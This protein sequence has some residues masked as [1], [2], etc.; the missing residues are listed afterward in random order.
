[1]IIYESDKATFM[2]YV[3]QGIIGDKVYEYYSKKVGN[4]KP[5]E[6]LAWRNSLRNMYS[7]LNTN[8]IPNDAGIAIEYMLPYQYS[9]IDFIVSGKDIRDAEHVIIVE[10][11]Q[12]TE[13]K[14]VVEK[15]LVETFVGGA[16][17]EL[18]H[19]S[20][21]AWSYAETLKEYN[22]TVQED[23]IQLH[24][25]S[26][27]HNYV[28]I[29]NDQLL[30]TIAYPEISSAPIF[31]KDDALELQQF[32]LKYIQKSDENNII[33]R[34]D[35]GKLKPSKSLQDS[36]AKMLEGNREFIMLDSQK[37]IYENIMHAVN[38][39]KN[40]NPSKTV[41]IIKGGPGTGKSVL[42][43][44]LLADIINCD[45]SVAY[46]TKN[47]APRNVYYEKLSGRFRKN[48]VNALFK[49]SGIFYDS[50][51]NAF[52][53]LLID[54]AHRLNEK[55]GLFS[56][57][58]ENQIKEIINASKISVFFIDEDQRVTSKD[59]GSIDLIKHFAKLFNAKIK[60][61]ELESQFR[62]NGSDDYI[63]WLNNL[64]EIKT[65]GYDIFNN[66]D[67]DFKIFD[68]LNEMCEAI[69]EKNKINNKSRIV[70]GYCWEWLSKKD[71]NSYDIVIP[72]E[73]FKAQ[74]NFN[75]TSTWA[76]DEDSINQ[77]GCIH[78][79]QGLEFDYV[80]V[81][82]GNDLRY[83]ND[84]VITDFSKRAKTDKSLSGLITKCRNGDFESLKKADILIRN[85]YK[86]L[87]TRGMKGC[88]VYCT[89]KELS[90][91]IKMRIH[92][93]QTTYAEITENYLLAAETAEHE[94][95]K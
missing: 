77:I 40:E 19:P 60:T 34:I 4:I 95:L 59:I 78:T 81:I 21:Q 88:Y 74:W 6:I 26:F 51:N 25:C 66:R 16:F 68:N 39:M 44:N 36:I 86:T 12:W 47:S 71:L 76:I 11:K 67:Y 73:N 89:D 93:S 90:N 65:N 80:G 7:V 41:F 48:V 10:L 18:T 62:C 31:T 75:N 56:N 28:V 37:M 27:L 35:S 64:L 58:G 50:P 15:H 13:A 42:A 38:H 53:V 33:F 1:M 49:S 91:Y 45:K 52:D 85:T 70:A 3:E 69:Y 32:I 92:N 22:K 87:M 94:K 20:Y 17:R 43:I 55:S 82:I 2:K 79:S 8:A 72:S 57:K 61:L 29:G 84:K 83:K 30:D 63:I 46:V 5:S 14:A 54:E 23:N 24:P 9:R